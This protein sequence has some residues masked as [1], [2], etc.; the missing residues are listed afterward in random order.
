MFFLGCFF[1]FSQL[2][3]VNSSVPY[4]YEVVFRLLTSFLSLSKWNIL[5][6]WSNPGMNWVNGTI[7]SNQK[8][9]PFSE[10]LESCSFIYFYSLSKWS[11]KPLF[12]FCFLISTAINWIIAIFVLCNWFLEFIQGFTFILNFTSLYFKETVVLSSVTK[13]PWSLI[14]DL[15]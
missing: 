4:S 1:H 2:Y 10:L 9:L 12:L 15:N 3:L 6:H 5:K 8:L 7:N 11:I 13:W 14:I